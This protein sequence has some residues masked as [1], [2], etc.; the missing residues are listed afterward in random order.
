MTRYEKDMLKFEK[1]G[2][3]RNEDGKY[4]VYILYEG[5]AG[6]LAYFLDGEYKRKRL[7]TKTFYKLLEE[8]K[9]VRVDHDEFRNVYKGDLS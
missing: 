6:G 2:V 7:H 1:Y 4:L 5:V 8:G 9:A 3:A